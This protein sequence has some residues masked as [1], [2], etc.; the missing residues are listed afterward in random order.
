M[1]NYEPPVTEVDEFA[2]A[3][4]PAGELYPGVRGVAVEVDGQIHIPLILGNGEG[5]VGEMLDVLSKRCR[6]ISV[7]SPKLKKMLE[8]RK[9]ICEVEETKDGPLDVW[10]PRK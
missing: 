2:P 9:W 1:R 7:I 8:R 6:V 3:W 4:E 5:K 10:R